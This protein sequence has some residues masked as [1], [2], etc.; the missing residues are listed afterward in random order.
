MS[1]DSHGPSAE[2]HE[3]DSTIYCVVPEDR[4][5]LRDVLIRYLRDVPGIEVISE[6]RGLDRRSREDRRHGAGQRQREGERRRFNPE[7]ERRAG[8][9]RADVALVKPPVPLPPEATRY[10]DEIVFVERPK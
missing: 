3:G 8:Y 4:P 7:P 1:S 2:S 6:R 10:A 9:R 5:H